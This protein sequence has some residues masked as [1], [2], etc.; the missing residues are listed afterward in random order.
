MKTLELRENSKKNN[1]A[2]STKL[3]ISRLPFIKK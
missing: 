2:V 1:W 3:L